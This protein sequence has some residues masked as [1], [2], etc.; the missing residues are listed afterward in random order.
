ME[1]TTILYTPAAKPSLFPTTNSFP[2]ARTDIDLKVDLV[3]ARLPMGAPYV[4]PRDIAPLV[5]LTDN[6]LRVHCRQCRQLKSWQGNYRFQMDDREHV[7]ALRALVKLVLWS[8]T[9]VPSEL[10]PVRATSQRGATRT[11]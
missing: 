2:S 11:H 8:G 5:G 1:A 6:A 9:K 7:D 4:C 3:M 10:K